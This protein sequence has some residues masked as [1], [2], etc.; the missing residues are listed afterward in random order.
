LIAKQNTLD[1]KKGRNSIHLQSH[2]LWFVIFSL[3]LGTSL[4]LSIIVIHHSFKSA[5]LIGK[6]ASQFSIN[7]VWK[8]IGDKERRERIGKLADKAEW[9][10]SRSNY[11]SIA[12]A[13][14]IILLLFLTWRLPK[15]SVNKRHQYSLIF[16][17]SSLF[18]LIPGVI[19]PA[20]S[21]LAYKK[22]PL[23]GYVVVEYQSRGIVGT[24][25]H[26]FSTNAFLAIM[27]GLF[28]IIIPSCKIVLSYFALFH[29]RG[30]RIVKIL[31]IIGKWSMAD[32]F[33]IAVLLSYFALS[34]Y[35]SSTSR[36]E[37]G[38]YFFSAYCILSLF[39]TEII[40]KG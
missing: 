19:A 6:A 29:K 21:F 17:T 30:N 32:V 8:N 7:S 14:P 12:T 36:I 3:C 25:I 34:S 26:L 20:L 1:I 23:L 9:H 11:L 39:S 10:R 31:K 13:L 18:A 24:I 4:F 33:V 5:K 38:L 40:K 35:D 15:G 37:H 16:V 22:I 2:K 27:I 28:S